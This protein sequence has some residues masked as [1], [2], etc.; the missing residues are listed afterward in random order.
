[1][2]YLSNTRPLLCRELVGREHELQELC[3][4]LQ[5]AA[6]G[7]PQL[8]LL[9]GEAGLGKT[10]LCRA[11]MQISQAQQVLILF[12]QAIPQ[13]AALPFGPFLDAFRRY[14]TSTIRTVPSSNNSLHTT[15]VSL[16]RLFPELAFMFP[17]SVLPPFG[18]DSTAIQ[19]Q[20]TVFHGILSALQ[21][22]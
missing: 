16:L 5:R 12:G 4:A 11:F 20:Q 7:E 10:K 13:D 19:S 17:A 9:A 8:V 6:S 21:E 3:E 2:Q 14:F 22:L 15:F 18:P 1:M